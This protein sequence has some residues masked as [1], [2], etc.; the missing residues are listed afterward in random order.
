M[1]EK[2]TTTDI[3]ILLE[4]KID[5]LNGFIQNFDNNIK[6]VMNKLSMLENLIK[7]QTN[8]SKTDN[9]IK[10]PMLS[11]EPVEQVSLNIKSTQEIKKIEKT[12]NSISG[13]VN[14]TQVVL[15]PDN[16]R[17]LYAVVEFFNSN[18][19]LVD[20]T[21]TNTS[22]RWAKKLVPGKYKVKISKS[23]PAFKLEYDILVENSDQTLELPVAQ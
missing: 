4:K 6:I 7:S 12:N 3:I 9:V 18:E 16:K 10:K 8:I 19:E 21:K 13:S 11:V 20:K 22:G 14:V 1:E 17:V 5:Q 23:N 2:R 15:Y